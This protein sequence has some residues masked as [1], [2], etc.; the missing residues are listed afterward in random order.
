MSLKSW[1]VETLV[2][3]RKPDGAPYLI[4]PSGGPNSARCAANAYLK[5]AEMLY[6]A[7][8][9]KGGFWYISEWY[10][11]HHLAFIAVELYLKAFNANIVTDSF[12]S[13]PETTF[14]QTEKS[15]EDLSAASDPRILRWLKPSQLNT[16][17]QLGKEEL[18]RGR[19]PYEAIEDP[20]SDEL[21][22]RFPSGDAGRYLTEEWLDL[23]RAL[24]NFRG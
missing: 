9:A 11:I 1:K 5:A 13:D 23:A 20:A 19:Y 2:K 17:L 24:Q 3:Y 15:H 14:T 18:T 4:G 12:S 16:L 21:I 6:K 22:E 8:L 7:E 10:V